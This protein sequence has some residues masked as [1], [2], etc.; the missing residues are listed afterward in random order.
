MH[1]EFALVWR[2]EG[3]KRFPEMAASWIIRITGWATP[4]IHH[5]VWEG[6]I[7]YAKLTHRDQSITY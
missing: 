5:T 3:Y 1:I 7:S 6:L 2:M 4:Q